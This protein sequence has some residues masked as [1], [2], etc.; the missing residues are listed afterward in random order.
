MRPRVLIVGG[1]IGGLVTAL[2][3]HARS[4]E[5]QVLERV[6]A[7]RP[8]GVGINLLPHAVAILHELGLAQALAAAAIPTAQLQY[9]NK[10][11]QLIWSEPRGVA[12]G[13]P[14]PQY[15]I[16]RG[17]LHS[18]LHEAVR[19]RLGPGAVQL[20]VSF[21]SAAQ[22]GALVT[23]RFLRHATQE[24]F[25]VSGAALIGADGIHSTVRA[26]FY[27]DEGAPKFAGRL[28]WRAVTEAAPFLD[29]RT[30]I[31]AG[32]PDQKFVCYPI[33]AQHAQRG[34]ALVNWIAE[35][36]V[37]QGA[38]PPQDWNRQVERTRFA[39]RFADWRYEWHDVP[40]LI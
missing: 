13:Y 33:C 5:V 23:G 6:S 18:L 25:E 9:Y 37:A 20:G 32:H 22:R 4:I 34:R 40:A 11:G 7:I 8:L 17:T 19:E 30:M 27:P 15:S 36:R 35:L 1:G 29:G 10:L 2:S 3:L 12:A 38:L 21:Q 14:V 28:L 26:G 31:L 24:S 16:H 39:D